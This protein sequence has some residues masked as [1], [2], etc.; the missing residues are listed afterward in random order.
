MDV[1]AFARWAISPGT[2]LSTHFRPGEDRCGIYVLEFAD[3][4]RYVGQSHDVVRRF[5]DHARTYPD[6]VGAQ[7]CAVQ[8]SDLDAAERQL[9]Q[10][11]RDL[12]YHLRNIVLVSQSWS[13]SV[14]DA[15]V[16]R[17]I[18]IS[19][20]AGAPRTHPDDL[21]MLTAR[22]R[23]ATRKKYAAL[24]EHRGFADVFTDIC[25]YVDRVIAW[26]SATDGRFWTLTALPSTGRSRQSQR[27]ACLSCGRVE[28]FVVLEDRESGQLWWFLNM[29]HGVVS[30]SS[31]PHDLQD[32]L[33]FSDNYRTVGTVDQ[34]FGGV[35][36]SL[37]SWLDETTNLETASRQLALNLM[38][39]GPSLF[40]RFHCDDF[41][42]DVLLALEE[43]R[44][45]ASIPAGGSGPLGLTGLTG[46]RPET[47]STSRV[48]H[49]GAASKV[50]WAIHVG[51]R[52]F[53]PT[54]VCRS[55]PVALSEGSRTMVQG[56]T[57]GR[58]AISRR[59]G[60]R[61]RV[62]WGSISGVTLGRAQ[63]ALDMSALT[64][65]ATSPG[66]A[67]ARSRKGRSWEIAARC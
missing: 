25:T 48:H 9:I 38:R 54:H 8:S 56:E 47:P 63:P 58:G 18:Q 62:P 21:R 55:E 15:V 26:P 33:T 49:Q 22:R 50:L 40:A 41:V 52:V 64:A 32:A 27:L 11:Q 57:H 53:A 59:E 16:D 6:I 2:S 39:K 45:V 7:F 19:W 28:T 23:R 1:S 42:D 31:L 20:T 65:S 24:Q 10:N 14:L 17:T 46:L 43:D 4:Q 51:K 3:G 34:V 36:G 30:R 44:Q 61:R 66:S 67:N 35:A 37:A 5:A 60:R 29:E 13:D 12:G